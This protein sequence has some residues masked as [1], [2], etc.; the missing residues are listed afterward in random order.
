MKIFGCILLLCSGFF[1]SKKLMLPYWNHYHIIQESI[2]MFHQIV[3]RIQNEK[4][5]LP[6]LLK[7]K[8]EHSSYWNYFFLN[9]IIPW[10]RKMPMIYMS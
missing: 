9:Y 8:S 1:A 2:Q 6:T 7:E 5:V 4:T 3:S 10:K